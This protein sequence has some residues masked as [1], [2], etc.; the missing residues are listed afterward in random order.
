MY[1]LTELLIGIASGLTA[2][3]YGFGERFCG[4]IG[5]PEACVAGTFTASGE[6]FRPNHVASAAVPATARLRLTAQWISLKLGG[7]YPCRQIRLND[8]S[9]PRWIGKRGYD[10]SPAAVR[11]LTNRPATRYWSHVVEECD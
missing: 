7:P 1:T 11:L 8:K 5:A 2:T 4:P 10:L 3:T 9:N 6:E